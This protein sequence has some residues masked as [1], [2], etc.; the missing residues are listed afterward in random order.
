MTATS[1]Q[2]R[3]TERPDG[4]IF[5][6]G[7]PEGISVA[8][9]PERELSRIA[10]A[11]LSGRGIFERIKGKVAATEFVYEEFEKERDRLLGTAAL[12]LTAEL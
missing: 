3:T 5:L 6:P 12:A 1:E 8:G 7:Y 11:I 2:P 9:N 4:V 10:F